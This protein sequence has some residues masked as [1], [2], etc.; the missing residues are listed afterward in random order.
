ML[1]RSQILALRAQVE[2]IEIEEGAL[3]FLSD[4]GNESSLR[5]AVQLLTPSQVISSTKDRSQVE[6]DDIEEANLLF[7]DAKRSAKVL[8]EQSDK[9]IV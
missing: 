8:Q 3:S 5:H 7:S 2:Q 9:Y 4:L 1:L 6:K